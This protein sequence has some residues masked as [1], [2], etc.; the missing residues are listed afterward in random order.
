MSADYLFQT[1]KCY[2]VTYDTGDKVIQC[3]RH[4]DIFKFWLQWR[5]RGM[6]GFEKQIDRLME[7]TY[8]QVEQMKKMPEKFYLINDEPECTN[9]IFWYI[10]TR[11]RDE[12]RGHFWQDELGKVTAVI[13]GKMMK[14][15]SMMISYQPLG[16]L[17][18]FFR[19]IISNQAQTEEDID[20]MLAELDRLGH[21]L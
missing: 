21:D 3:G 14:T 16:E 13:K 11:L 1:D 7:L 10:P 19:S 12:K 5:S 9:V 8:Y 20:F 6:S 18:N 4:N 17:P 2:D 15:G